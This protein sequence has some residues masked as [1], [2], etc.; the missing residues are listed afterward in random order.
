M[1]FHFRTLMALLSFILCLTAAPHRASAEDLFFLWGFMGANGESSYSWQIDY[2]QELG[3]YGGFSVGYLN[4]GHVT[5]HHRD[6]HMLQFWLWDDFFNDKLNLAAGAGAFYYYDTTASK[7]KPSQPYINDHGIG[8]SLS[9]SA[10]WV[11]DSRWLLQ[12]RSNINLTESSIN[13][14]SALLGVGYRLEEPAHRR[15]DRIEAV[16]S[17]D[18]PTNTIS[19]LIGKTIINSFDSEKSGNIGIEYRRRLMKYLDV[20]GLWLLEGDSRISRRNGVAG[21]IWA[22]RDFFDNRFGVGIG[23]GPYFSLN[24]Y[25]DTA[26]NYYRRHEISGIATISTKYAFHEHWEMRVSWNRIITGYDRDGD[27]MML[28]LGYRF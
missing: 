14:Y 2:R 3:R 16:S 18:V 21:Q 25:H 4:E 1:K 17:Y 27:V 28:G 11:F 12:L 7:L 6:G 9:A 24:R 22:V 8:A 5:N 26:D 20:S 13:T 15:K 10:T 23:I 19:L